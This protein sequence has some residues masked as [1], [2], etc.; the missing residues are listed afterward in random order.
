MI[1][2]PYRGGVVV[3]MSESEKHEVW[4]YL[5]YSNYMFGRLAGPGDR[6]PPPVVENILHVIDANLRLNLYQR[7][8]IR[9]V[10]TSQR[11]A[12]DNETNLGIYTGNRVLP[13][14]N[15]HIALSPRVVQT[16]RGWQFDAGRAADALRRRLKRETFPDPSVWLTFISALRGTPVNTFSVYPELAANYTASPW[17]ESFPRIFPTL[18]SLEKWGTAAG[19]ILQCFA[20][21][22]RVPVAT[23]GKLLRVKI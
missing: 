11:L 8:G 14:I 20:T 18:V 23:V 10:Q 15:F 5:R 1:A 12:V 13:G 22:R 6:L 7:V 2:V 19:E 4:S 21:A 9:Y 16:F 3:G 17:N